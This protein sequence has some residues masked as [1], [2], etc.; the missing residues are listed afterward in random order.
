MVSK[1]VEK[2]CT[3]VHRAVRSKKK[4]TRAG[5]EPAQARLGQQVE[6]MFT[7]WPDARAV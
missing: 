5:F 4:P 6:A 7:S 3:E 1:S 2:R